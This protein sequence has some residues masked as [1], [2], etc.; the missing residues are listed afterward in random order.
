MRPTPSIRDSYDFLRRAA[1]QGTEF[2]LEQFAEASGWA[3]ST[4]QIYL[5]KKLRG[6]VRRV[7]PD[8]YQAI[9]GRVRFPEY[10]Q[11][12]AQKQSLFT[13]YKMTLYPDVIIYDFFLPLTRED[14]LR[15]GLENLFYSNRIEQL[16]QEI[17]ITEIESTFSRREGETDQD[18]RARVCACVGEVF[19]GYSVFNVNGRFRK[20]AL[21]SEA[22]AVA[23]GP[24]EDAYVVDETTAVVRFIMRCSS[25]SEDVGM[26]AQQQPRLDQLG[27]AREEMQQVQ[28]VFFK[29]FAE[30]VVKHVNYEDEIWLLETG[31]VDADGRSHRLWVWSAQR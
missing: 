14:R 25:T 2:T 13:D 7:R 23:R 5:S 9:I 28:W 10:E 21:V 24:F 16:L 15:E 20:G 12:F 30:A 4:V 3:P 1:D 31:A 18:L 29:I 6:L 11:L 26:D 17:D 27:L 19:V 8:T 22:E